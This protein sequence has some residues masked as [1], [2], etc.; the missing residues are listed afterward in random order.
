MYSFND[1]AGHEAGTVRMVSSLAGGAFAYVAVPNSPA[2]NTS[3]GATQTVNFGF[4][5]TLNATSAASDTYTVRLD[6]AGT[7]SQVLLDGSVISSAPVGLAA[8]YA[9][10]L[11][12]ANDAL[13][14]DASNGSPIPTGGISVSGTAGA[15]DTL[16]ILG[17]A[18]TDSYLVNSGSVVF[19][20]RTITESNIAGLTLNPGGGTSS[21]NVA[22]GSATLPATNAGAGF[23]TRTFSSISIGSSASLSIATAAAHSD[24]TLILTPALWIA[25]GGRFDLG[26]NDL[27]LQAGGASGLALLNS[28]AG[29]GDNLGNWNGAGLA[30]SAAAADPRHLTALGVA[31]A[32]V[33]GVGKTIDG[34][35]PAATDVLVKYTWYG[36]TNLD[37]KVDG[38]DYTRIDFATSA[39][40]STGWANGDFN[41][42]TAIDG[43]DYSLIDNTY[44]NQSAPM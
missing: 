43:S 1:L 13:I 9:F 35:S 31:P 30:S 10:S 5:P 18:G 8:T 27:V 22:S 20:G 17:S 26:G 11:A 36:D 6:P 2:M 21:L 29:T 44:N 23:L 32:S 38:S 7:Q 33:F 37:G 28:L 12:G 4:Y 34:Y 3:F 42:D 15:N 40:G 41:Y 24:R 39:P 16:T 19:S 14:V 25:T